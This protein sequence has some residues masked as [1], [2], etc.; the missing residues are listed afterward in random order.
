MR[1]LYT[2]CF[3]ISFAAAAVAKPT[4]VI[5]AGHG[6]HDRGGM[7]GQRVPEKGYALDVAQRL[8]SVLQAAGYRTIMTRRS[9]VFVGLGERARMANSAG[10]AIFVSVHFNGARNYDA[11][12]IETY[13]SSGRK[14]AAL[15]TSIHRSVLSATG[16]IDRRVRSRRFYV[17]R[18]TRVPAVLCELG[19]LTNKAE[20]KKIASGSYRQR[21]AEAIARGIQA[22]Y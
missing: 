12:G 16:S 2:I 1:W 7:P 4:V 13:Y 20:A 6:G 5:D 3:I 10:S 11:Y 21:L 8:E 18:N 19:F 17:L 15:A 22:R 9:D 14:S